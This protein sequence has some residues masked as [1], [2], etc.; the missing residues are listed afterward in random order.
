MANGVLLFWLVAAFSTNDRA[1]R[2]IVSTIPVIA[3][4]GTALLTWLGTKL[5][6]EKLAKISVGSYI[7]KKAVTP[8]E[9]K[10]SVQRTES[11][12]DGLPVDP[13]I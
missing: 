10:G 6:A 1:L 13:N 5:Y 9:R 2:F 4:L 3:S 7:K 8:L 11:V 12:A